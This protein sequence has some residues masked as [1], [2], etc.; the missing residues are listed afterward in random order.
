MIRLAQRSIV[1]DD[2]YRGDHGIARYARE[3]VSRLSIEWRPLG[4]SLRPGSPLDVLNPHRIRLSRSTLL[5]SPGYSAGATASTQLLT[6][7][8]LIHLRAGETR[9]SRLKRAYYERVVKP[10]IMQAGH[11]MTVSE[12]SST[13]IREW[14]EDDNVIV[15]NTGNGCAEVFTPDGPRISMG[16]PYFLYVGNFKRHKNPALAF[17]A[18]KSFPKH[19][20]VVVTSDV[21]MASR[22]AESA[23][24]INRLEVISQIDDDLLAALYRGSEALLFPSLWEGFGLPVLEALAAGTKVVY[25]ASARSVQEICRDTQFEVSNSADAEEFAEA[26]RK[27]LSAPFSAPENLSRFHWDSVAHQ[28]NATLQ[29]LLTR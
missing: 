22:M 1:I 20:M 19:K 6:V 26:M 25:C 21:A 12:T 18:M 17:A 28:V 10:A 2:R 27:A 5:Y 29:D 15:H 11:V 8:D 13:D 3:V 4:K 9:A 7:H 24:F 14:I 16:S 23:G